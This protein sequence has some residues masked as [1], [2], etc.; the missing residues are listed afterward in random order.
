[1]IRILFI[2]SKVCYPW[3]GG[4]YRIRHTLEA[5]VALG[6]AV[7]LVTIPSEYSYAMEGIT[8]YEVPRL[9]FCKR[10]P[11][12]PS[13][14]R[15][16]LDFLLLCRAVF[17][18]GHVRYDLIHGIDDCG[19]IAWFTGALSKHP[20][21][22]ELQGDPD[23]AQISAFRRG[24]R[25]IV[26]VFNRWALKHADVVISGDMEA[27]TVLAQ[28]GRGARVC[29]IPDIPSVAEEVSFP[30]QNLARARYCSGGKLLVTCVGSY[31]NFKGMDLFFNAM[32]QVLSKNTQV[33]FVV[34]GGAATAI[35]KMK[36]A[37]EQVGIDQSVV[38]T[39]YVPPGELAAL[40]SVST[41]L[42]APSRSGASVSVK[43]L[44]YL[45]AGKP[46][47]A[48]D[49]PV[50]RTL[51]SRRNA[52]VVHPEPDAMAEAILYACSHP[53]QAEALGQS[54]FATLTEEERTPQAF[55]DALRRCYGYVVEQ[56]DV[57]S[58]A[59]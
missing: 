20:Y 30:A 54:A 46:I 36:Q 10:L 6:Y 44:D 3:V 15:Y 29:V 28:W 49:T 5:L 22:Y 31:Q 33:R 43:V 19:V 26:S 13:I 18:T 38:F 50:Y 14:R 4:S 24:L 47:V 8:V 27:V 56:T 53:Q 21:V 59:K 23:S 37:V 11:D 16:V 9:P 17:Q 35:K 45:R 52:Y 57:E 51:L 39:G 40:L 58:G 12:G 1:M 2:T 55:Q 42:V 7:D 48:P 41:V 25:R 32:P 34:V